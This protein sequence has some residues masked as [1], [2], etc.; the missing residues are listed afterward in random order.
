[1]EMLEAFV[2]SIIMEN[3]FHCP[4]LLVTLIAKSA[5]LETRMNI[6]KSTALNLSTVTHLLAQFQS[7]IRGNSVH[8][9]LHEFPPTHTQYTAPVSNKF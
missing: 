4:L 9:E 8:S 2:E 6:N 5:E 3:K 7:Y 1:M